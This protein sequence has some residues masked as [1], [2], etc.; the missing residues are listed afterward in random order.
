[1]SVVTKKIASKQPGRKAMRN[2]AG[3]STCFVSFNLIGDL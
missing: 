3:L 1:V 2:S